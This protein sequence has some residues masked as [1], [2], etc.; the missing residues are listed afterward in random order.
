M[1]RETLAAFTSLAPGQDR[2]A[3]HHVCIESWRRAGAEIF[4]FN[5]PSEIAA[6]RSLYDINFVPVCETSAPVFG[7]H[8]IPISTMLS[9]AGMRRGPVLI[10]NADIELQATPFE[11]KRIRWL[12][13]G[14][15][16][17]FV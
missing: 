3:H 7:Q 4:S 14:A 5:H 2:A 15:L 17:Y 13:E 10:I 8:Y 6:L 12:C 16:C 1:A 11:L 9:L